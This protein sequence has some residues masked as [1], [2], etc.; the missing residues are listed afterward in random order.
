MTTP[1]PDPPPL[2]AHAE[3]AYLR[4]LDHLRTCPPCGTGWPGPPPCRGAHYLRRA[5][6]AARKAALLDHR[7]NQATR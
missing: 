1:T 5:L 4:L 7:T 2:E 3:R 6:R